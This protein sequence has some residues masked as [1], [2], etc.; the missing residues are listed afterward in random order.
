MFARTV[1]GITHCDGE[2]LTGDF[3]VNASRSSY[4]FRTTAERKR[5]G[6]K[7]GIADYALEIIA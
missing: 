5:L 1:R 7:S 2:Y 3:Y 6:A 4:R